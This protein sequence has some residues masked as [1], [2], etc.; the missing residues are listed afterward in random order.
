VL[1]LLVKIAWGWT[2]KVI[3]EAIIVVFGILIHPDLSNTNRIFLHHI[4]AT[5]PLIWASLSENMS[6]MWAQNYFHHSSTHPYLVITNGNNRIPFKDPLWTTK[7]FTTTAE[8]TSRTL[9]NKYGQG[10][11][12]ISTLL[13][14]ELIVTYE[15]T[16]YDKIQIRMR[17]LQMQNLNPT[18]MTAM[19]ENYLKHFNNVIDKE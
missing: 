9:L 8:S 12:I 13:S 18:T 1:P 6:N 7:T 2:Y 19:T 15:Y 17:K 14:E 10:S 4:Y 16:K 3:V 11:F 5:A